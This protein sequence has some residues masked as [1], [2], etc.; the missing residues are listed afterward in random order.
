MDPAHRSKNRTDGIVVPAR[1]KV[2]I[3]DN[4]ALLR[5]SY[6]LNGRPYFPVVEVYE[7]LD[8]YYADARFEV[9]EMHEMGSDHGRTYPDRNLIFIREDVY[10][11]ACAGEGRDRFTM[12]HE[13]GHLMMHRGVALSRIDPASPPAIFRNSE[14]QA[15][16]FA[17]YLMMPTDLVA[18]YSARALH[19]VAAEFG[20]SQEAAWARRSDM[21]K[22]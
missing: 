11:R 12:C 13:L 18:G 3:A 17:S 6:G 22:A 5:K 4:A 19:A 7:A 9:L 20:V 2:N 8:L 21:K 1:S 16:T 15:D 14:W 10:K